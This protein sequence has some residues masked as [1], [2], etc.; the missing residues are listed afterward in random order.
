MG[1]FPDAVS[2]RASDHLAALG[3]MVGAGHQ[4]VVVY[5]VQRADV[6]R[7]QQ[8]IDANHICCSRQKSRYWGA[9]H[10][11]FQLILMIVRNSVLFC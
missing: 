11:Q 7:S 6:N 5:C 10:V 8:A 3:Q 2:K 4:A 1:L 9:I